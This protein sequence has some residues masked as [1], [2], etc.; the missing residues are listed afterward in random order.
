MPIYS[1]RVDLGYVIKPDIE[2]ESEAE[3]RSAAADELYE[4]ASNLIPDPVKGDCY[5]VTLADD[6]Q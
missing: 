1:V 4:I 6:S 5:T 2:A 3:A